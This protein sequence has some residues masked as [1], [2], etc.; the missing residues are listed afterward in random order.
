LPFNFSCFS[1]RTSV[2]HKNTKPTFLDA[3]QRINV[4][5][6]LWWQLSLTDI[7]MSF[8]YSNCCAIK[9]QQAAGNLYCVT[10]WYDGQYPIYRW[11]FKGIS[12]SQS[13]RLKICQC[14]WHNLIWLKNYAEIKS[15]YE[16]FE[17][18]PK[19]QKGIMKHILGQWTNFRSSSKIFVMWR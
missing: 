8:S 13:Y 11:Q 1:F 10:E 14:F 12:S 2:Q 19:P 18:V 5:L 3:L 16:I 4:T 17:N 7:T 15:C 9:G 6:P